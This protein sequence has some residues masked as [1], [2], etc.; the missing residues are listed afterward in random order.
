MLSD[1]RGRRWF[2]LAIPSVREVDA[3]FDPWGSM[4][5]R[6]NWRLGVQEYVVVAA[7]CG[8]AVDDDGVQST[9][10]DELTL[11]GR[12]MLVGPTALVVSRA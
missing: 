8:H 1:C 7:G 4:A 5:G 2:F 12:S 10:A 11:T 9:S 3:V 6:P